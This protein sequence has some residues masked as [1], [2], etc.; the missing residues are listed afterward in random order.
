MRIFS[1]SLRLLILSVSAF[2]YAPWAQ[3]GSGIF[4]S[5]VI[6][7]GTYY[8]AGAATA[9]ADFLN[10]NLGA[11][12]GTPTIT[13]SGGEIKTFKN[14]VDDICGGTLR[15]RVYPQGSPSGAFSALSLNYN[16]AFGN[17]SSP[18]SINQK[19]DVTGQTINLLSGLTTS[20]T[21]V[22]DIYFEA[23][24][25][26]PCGNAPFT[27]FDNRGGLNYTAT[28]TFACGYVNVANFE[29]P[30]SGSCPYS[31]VSTASGVTASASS[32]GGGTCGLL[33]GTASGSQAFIAN[34]TAGQALA[35]TNAANAAYFQIQ[36]N[37]VTAY[38]EYQFYCQT[39]RSGA[40]PTTLTVQYSTNGTNY[41]NTGSTI[42]VSSG[43]YNESFIDLSSL[44]AIHNVAT[45]YFR[46]IFSGASAST[47]T[48]RMDNFQLRARPGITPNTVADVCTGAGT[49]S[50][51]FTGV[52][53]SPYQ[54]SL[55]A[56]TP[57][58]MAGFSAVSNTTLPASPISVTIPT[59]AATG[60]YNFALSMRTNTGC[61]LTPLVAFSMNV[62]APPTVTPSVA[63][64][65][66]SATNFSLSY[67]ATGSPNQYSVASA[68]P[69]PLT[70]FTAVNNASIAASPIPISLPT[71]PAAGTYNFTITVQNTALNNCISAA[72]PFSVT[73]NA[74]PSITLGTVADVCRG[75]ASFSLPY[76]ATTGGANQYSIAAPSPAMSGFSAVTN[77][78][79]AS[80]PIAVSLPAT[81]TA[82]AYSFSMTVR[83]SGTGCVSAATPFALTVNTVP[84]VNIGA[85]SPICVGA[86]SFSLPY[87]ATFSPTTYSLSAGTPAMSGF[88]PISN[89][90]IAAS[91][92]AV[93]IPAAVAGSYGFSITA[94]NVCGA[95]TVANGTLLV[96]ALPAVSPSNSSPVCVGGTLTLTTAPANILP[97]NVLYTWSGPSGYSA[98][99]QG[100]A[101]EFAT[102]GTTNVTW[103]NDT[104]LRNWYMSHSNV[105]KTLFANDGS[106]GT[107][108]FYNFGTNADR[109]LGAVRSGAV[110]NVFWGVKIINTTGKPIT[111][112]GVQYTG[113]QWRA[114]NTNPQTLAFTYQVNASTLTGGTGTWIPQ[115]ALNFV[116]P[117]ASAVGALNGNLAANRALKQGSIILG[118]P[119]AAG[120]SIWLRWELTAP[121]TGSSHGLAIDDL[122]VFAGTA[123]PQ[124]SNVSLANAGAYTLAITDLNGCTN[125]ASTTA[126]ITQPSGVVSGG[127]YVCSAGDA[128]SVNLAFTGVA[129]FT[130]SLTNGITNQTA[131]GSSS[132]VSVSPTTTATYT[133]TSLTD[134]NNCPAI[135]AG[136]TGSAT[137]NVPPS[138]TLQANA[139]NDITICPSSSASL[140]GNASGGWSPYTYSWN[141]GI[142][143]TQNAS[144]SPSAT[145]TYTLTVT[146]A[147]N[148]TANDGV[149]ITVP[150][151]SAASPVLAIANMQLLASAECTV[152]SGPD[153]GW[154]HYYS[155]DGAI[156][157]SLKKNGNNIGSIGNAGFS[158]LSATT[159]NF[160]SNMATQIT[161]PYVSNP[162]GWYVMNRW[163]DVQPNTQPTTPV[164]VRMYYTQADINDILGSVPTLTGIQQMT[165]YKINNGSI[166]PNPAA[167][168]AN[169][170]YADVQAYAYSATASSSN[171]FTANAYGSNVYYAEFQVP[172]F[173]GG[174]GGGGTGGIGFPVEWLDI[175]AEWM[176]AEGKSL[177]NASISWATASE[178]NN[179]YFGIER[180]YD[181][182]FFEEV[183]RVSGAGTTTATS[184]YRFMDISPLT[185]GVASLLYRIRQVDIDGKFA[186]SNTVELAT[187]APSGL[188]EW[189]LSPNPT[190]GI[191]RCQLVSQS[192]SDISLEIID[193]QG[194][195]IWQQRH[196]LHNGVNILS[197]PTQ[198]LAAGTYLVRLLSEG[199]NMSRK[200]I[201]R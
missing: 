159:P 135:V 88:T 100:T 186:Y 93:S 23:A 109:A 78:T 192:Q 1:L 166:D 187:V 53:G 160:G 16:S 165:F 155:N 25:G 98:I 56:T 136:M 105:A 201:V 33:S 24:G 89:A 48:I 124:I 6:I 122:A 39:T 138:G 189:I 59:S 184:E 47:G 64:V 54:Y 46:F 17:V 130:Y 68:S 43:S 154:T 35:V 4:E 69:N 145:T 170:V 180:S 144:A 73:I 177:P 153:A 107:G 28:F 171:T 44:S 77:A 193:A 79:L 19:W 74:T 26:L 198:S 147:Q 72:T 161:A 42:T 22:V 90:A 20:G 61:V 27:L 5:Y 156:L 9:N 143:A 58:A 125:S 164:K 151:F 181:G 80:S 82:Q 146:D 75:V 188:S 57:N 60:T 178:T 112:L 106:S 152:S 115:T 8:D 128:S 173:S 15:Y 62:I 63:A 113:E 34:A 76:S 3:A 85:I 32:A 117:I 123:S 111:A 12:Y 87:T 7:N 40:G 195:T 97:T 182:V 158:V 196:T 103:R 14:G 134:A 150:N 191:T 194:R 41:T 126:V 84:T 108:G 132:S 36:V 174:G 67:S 2:F 179:A 176:P 142:G 121:S 116:S 81:P 50:L 120:D 52:S 96:N 131:S 86:T 149:T 10:A 21:Y 141:N 200:L 199:E 169:A 133:L 66:Q 140:S 185:N 110:G 104:T 30:T 94:S 101:Q 91:P 18:P 172:H 83:N 71:T 175:S 99:A 129:P 163:W 183:G 137:V 31:P 65:C 51:P 157:L 49:F 11:Y 92:I 38:R 45:F 119:L 190:E 95:S 70:G 29:F 197:L 55:S 37:N 168:H 127:G 148:C 167:N 139:G 162:G 114:N 102:L 13:L 118:T